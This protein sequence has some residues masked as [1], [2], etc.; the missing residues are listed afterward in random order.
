MDFE[1]YANLLKQLFTNKYII[2]TFVVMIM[3]L[4]FVNYVLHYKKKEKKKK[5]RI[6]YEESKP[7]TTQTPSENTEA[8]SE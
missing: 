1:E 4:S 5:G 6:I 7:Q 2:I 8:N 3:I